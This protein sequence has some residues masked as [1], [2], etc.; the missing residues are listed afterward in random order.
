[1]TV[2]GN[3]GYS[4]KAYNCD[5]AIHLADCPNIAILHELLH[6]RSISYY[7]ASVYYEYSAVEEATVQLLAEEISKFEGI[8]VIHSETY[9]K[10]V[11]ILR[12]FNKKCI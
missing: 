10:W 6:A 4:F 3:R 11:N 5:I 9:N 7:P 8:P 2:I 12:Y 1:M